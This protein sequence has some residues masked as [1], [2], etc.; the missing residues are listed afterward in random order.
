MEVELESISVGNKEHIATA[1]RF[2]AHLG[3]P[4]TA[5][6]TKKYILA[7]LQKILLQRQK[8]EIGLL[9]DRLESRIVDMWQEVLTTLENSNRKLL[10]VESG[11]LI[12]ML[13]CPT[14]SS[15]LELKNDSWIKS[16]TLQLEKLLKIIG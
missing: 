3:N 15:M 12:F 11:S 5:V 13:F 9:I 7:F 14:N 8:L 1:V 16:L 6:D 4:D 2:G 10:T